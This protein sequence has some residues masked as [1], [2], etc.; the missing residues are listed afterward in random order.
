MSG[1]SILNGVTLALVSGGL[2]LAM[3]A[4][5][6]SGHWQLDA[7][8]SKTGSERTVSIDLAEKGNQVTFTRV[9][10]DHD[11]KQVTA[12]FTCAVGSQDCDFVEN[13]HKAKV[14]LWY[15]GPE[16]VVLK[17]DGE[18]HDSTVEW[19]LKLSDGGKTLNVNREIMEPADQT[20]KLVFNKAE[21]V[22]SR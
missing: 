11:G 3:D 2:C 5:D 6:F 13:G 16:L 14:S 8:K 21:S 4:V 1:R 22:A 7:A 19:H 20:E 12:T 9:F 15:N 18:K 10:D 17:T